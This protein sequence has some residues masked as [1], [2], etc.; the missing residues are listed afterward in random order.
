MKSTTP[1]QAA[2][3]WKRLTGQASRSTLVLTT[4]VVSTVSRDLYQTG[5]FLCD[6]H[7]EDRV[8]EIISS[9]RVLRPQVRQ[10]RLAPHKRRSQEREGGRQPQINDRSAQA[11][12]E[13]KVAVRRNSRA[14]RRFPKP[15]R[16]CFDSTAQKER[17]VRNSSLDGDVNEMED[18]LA[19]V[20]DLDYVPLF[21]VL[22]IGGVDT[23]VVP[24]EESR[25]ASKLLVSTLGLEETCKKPS[26]QSFPKTKESIITQQKAK[27]LEELDSLKELFSS[28]DEQFRN[29]PK[30]TEP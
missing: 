14:V 30:V 25:E 19:Q 12:P 26:Q 28:V 10:E 27:P 8:F 21:E 24:L 2:G 5:H 13:A 15:A 29:L 9:R 22:P 1:S 16:E 4:C 20:N 11:L 23:S 3:T 18:N 7:D 17:K 6:Y